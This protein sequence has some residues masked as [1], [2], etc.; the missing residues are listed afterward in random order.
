MIARLLPVLRDSYNIFT[1]LL[2]RAVLQKLINRNEV[3]TEQGIVTLNI[4]YNTVF[5]DLIILIYYLLTVFLRCSDLF[6]LFFHPRF[7]TL[8]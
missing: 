6:R 4:H 2:F 7:T 8:P 5:I 3:L 1:I